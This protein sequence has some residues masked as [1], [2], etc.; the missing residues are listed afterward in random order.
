MEKLGDEVEVSFCRG[1]F[2][3]CLRMGKVVGG[4]V[5]QAAGGG[6]ERGP[7]VLCDG[8]RQR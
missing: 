4:S 1:V 8:V 7:C 3:L 5:R 6:V 2:N